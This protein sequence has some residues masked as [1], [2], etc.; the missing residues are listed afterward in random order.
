MVSYGDVERMQMVFDSIW[1]IDIASFNAMIVVCLKNGLNE[2]ILVYRCKLM[3]EGFS[4]DDSSLSCALRA[5]G[6]LKSCNLGEMVH[7]LLEK[8]MFRL[9]LVVDTALADM[10]M[11]HDKGEESCKV[12]DGMPERSTISYNSM[13]LGHGQ[14]RNP[15]EAVDL[16]IEM[17]HL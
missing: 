12:F 14:N 15:D 6:G 17:K 4:P 8:T 9:E 11:K 5:C 2:T 7:G 16:F 1:L 3:F 10:Y 13:I